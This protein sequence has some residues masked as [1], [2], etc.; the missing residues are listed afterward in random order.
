MD[1][2]RIPLPG[3]G[4]DYSERPR[5]SGRKM[6]EKCQCQCVEDCIHAVQPL[7]ESRAV[8]CLS[9]AQLSMPP[10]GPDCVVLSKRLRSMWTDL[11][12]R[13]AA[14][15]FKPR[16]RETH[17]KWPGLRS[18]LYSL[19]PWME[20]IF[21]GTIQAAPFKKIIFLLSAISGSAWLAGGAP[22]TW[23]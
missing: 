8:A 14:A 6:V 18:W 21:V 10:H 1:W 19:L 7:C 2:V 13:A 22:I 5:T 11:I 15:T 9:V 4:E 3:R 16:R 23:L 20:H 17:R 12:G